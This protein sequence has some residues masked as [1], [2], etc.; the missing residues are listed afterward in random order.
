LPDGIFT[1]QKLLLGYTYFVGPWNVRYW[2]IWPFGL[3]HG[4]LV[5]FTAVWYIFPRFG[6]L[7]QGKSGNPGFGNYLTV[8][9][10][11]RLWLIVYIC[12]V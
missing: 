3:F 10:H 1:N 6:M 8:D 7:Y 5:Y 9:A 11:V 12:I 4:Y 2:Y